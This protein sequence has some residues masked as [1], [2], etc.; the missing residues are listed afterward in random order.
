MI[1]EAFAP[2]MPILIELLKK[3]KIKNAYFFGS[4]LTDKFN[5][6]SDLDLLI[7]FQDKVKPLNLEIKNHCLI[8]IKYL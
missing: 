8:I 3:H 4:V 5:E 6:E 7:N 1:N 2:Q